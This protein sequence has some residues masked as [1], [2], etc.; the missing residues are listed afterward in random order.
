MLASLTDAYVRL[1]RP[2]VMGLVSPPTL[3]K[4]TSEG[5]IVNL[6][7]FTRDERLAATY[8][9]KFYVWKDGLAAAPMLVRKEDA[10]ALNELRERGNVII[11]SQLKT[12]GKV[13]VFDGIMIAVRNKFV[14]NMAWYSAE[15][16]YPPLAVGE[17]P[18]Y[19]SPP[20]LATVE[21]IISGEGAYVYSERVVE[22]DVKKL[23]IPPPLALLGIAGWR[24]RRLAARKEVGE[25]R[26]NAEEG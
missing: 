21:S 7:V 26:R 3:D 25:G 16:G 14:G 4:V 15:G 2:L 23:L 5:V 6:E 24:M 22:V 9:P 20:L 18:L 1:K 8:F 13:Y 12:K 17:E 19:R 11:I 10:L